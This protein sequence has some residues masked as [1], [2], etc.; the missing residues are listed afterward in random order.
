M[1]EEAISRP[2]RP[3]VLLADDH[4]MVLERVQKL[5]RNCEIVGTAH[6]GTDLVTEA[7]RLHPDV[8]VSD[9]T[10]PMLNGIDAA[11]EVREAGSI[12]RFVVLTVHEES[13]FLQACF[14][15]GALVTSRNR[16]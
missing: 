9:I 5:L 11:H 14:A 8:I 4:D 10:M 1:S 7:L 2:S 6:N 15:E 16:I 13:E 3:R 12:S